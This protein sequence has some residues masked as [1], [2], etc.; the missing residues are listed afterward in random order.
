MP[1]TRE[2]ID[3]LD[4]DGKVWLVVMPPVN[5]CLQREPVL[6]LANG[7]DRR[8][9]DPLNAWHDL[10]RADDRRPARSTGA[11]RNRQRHVHEG[12]RRGDA[13]QRRHHRRGLVGPRV[14]GTSRSRSRAP[15]R[16]TA[17]HRGRRGRHP[18]RNHDHLRQRRPDGR[19]PGRQHRDHADPDKIGDAL[20][21]LV[22]PGD[23]P[24]SSGGR[25]DL[26]RD[27]PDQQHHE[28]PIGRCTGRCR[29]H[30]RHRGAS[31]RCHAPF[32]P[33][34]ITFG[35]SP[36]ATS[37]ASTSPSTLP[38]ARRKSSARVA[39]RWPRSSPAGRR[40]IDRGGDW[41]RRRFRR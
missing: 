36:A 7:G 32:A 26:L 24:F 17:L 3:F 19:D 40:D 1:T 41:V 21:S 9:I 6:R 16:T 20:H 29:H 22:R 27:Q 10:P 30:P 35:S 25:P 28:L 33:E 11:D 37:S 39:W 14:P 5:A 2:K 13:D 4:E 38:E 23:R 15:V 34:S 8:A 31:A 18:G 12:S